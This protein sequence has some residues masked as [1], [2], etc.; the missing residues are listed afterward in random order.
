MASYLCC[1]S[2]VSKYP[3]SAS[4]IAWLSSK[5]GR[6]C[7]NTASVRPLS[8][9][10]SSRNNCSFFRCSGVMHGSSGTTSG[11][12]GSRA[13]K[14]SCAT[15]G[16][17]M[18]METATAAARNDANDM[19]SPMLNVSLCTT[20]T[21]PPSCL[22]HNQAKGRRSQQSQTTPWASSHQR[23]R[24]ASSDLVMHGQSLAVLFSCNELCQRRK[25]RAA[26][27]HHSW[28]HVAAM[29]LLWRLLGAMLI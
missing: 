1:A 28:A 2:A 3:A 6:S 16:S 8:R 23:R 12:S 4:S 17:A 11:L 18:I 24:P 26:T 21:H 27:S 5:S 20:D 25:A 19:T 14:C 9:S 22:A 10:N 29:Q 7:S 13:V 15:A